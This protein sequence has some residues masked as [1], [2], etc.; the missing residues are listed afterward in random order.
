MK[1]LYIAVFLISII[2]LYSC[3]KNDS[4]VSTSS[5][6]L[7]YTFN[8]L[9]DSVITIDFAVGGSTT[10]QPVQYN[11]N[12]NKNPL[13]ERFNMTYITGGNMTLN[14]YYINGTDTIKRQPF[15]LSFA[16]DS[17]RNNLIGPI[18]RVE[19]VPVN[20]KGRGTIR[21]SK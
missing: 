7:S 5:D 4:V 21:I 9:N 16:V 12:L 18:N 17:T 13:I 19:I 10:S 2:S 15:T 1:K 14:R 20:F 8:N 11:V 6:T 3:S